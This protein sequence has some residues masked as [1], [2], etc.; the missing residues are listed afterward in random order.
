MGVANSHF[1]EAFQA[2]L[3]TS[4]AHNGFPKRKA[5]SLTSVSMYLFF[6][7]KLYFHRH[8]LSLSCLLHFLIIGWWYPDLFT[9]ESPNCLSR[10]AH[11]HTWKILTPC[12]SHCVS[13]KPYS[14]GALFWLLSAATIQTQLQPVPHHTP[15]HVAFLLPGLPDKKQVRSFKRETSGI[16][17]MRMR[18]CP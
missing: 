18:R 13:G 5:S 8:Y 16:S 1:S 12:V 4:P 14:R 2:S 17:A 15:S 11:G 10:G 9:E 3:K 6:F 7:T